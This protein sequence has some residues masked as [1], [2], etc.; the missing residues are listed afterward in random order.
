[1]IDLLCQLRALYTSKQVP[2]HNPP[3][4][5]VINFAFHSDFYV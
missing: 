5:I 1:M 2:A 3:V 4:T